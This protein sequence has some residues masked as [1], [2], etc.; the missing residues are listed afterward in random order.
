LE[1]SIGIRRQDNSTEKVGAHGPP[2]TEAKGEGRWGHEKL[3]PKR[4]GIQILLL[5]GARD[6]PD[7][8]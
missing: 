8:E 2:V 3:V 6:T 5:R 7:M 1:K 4:G